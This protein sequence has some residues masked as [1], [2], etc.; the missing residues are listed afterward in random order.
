[1]NGLNGV[2]NGH[3]TISSDDATL[4]EKSKNSSSSH[5]HKSSSKDKHRD[6]DRD[7]HRDHKS[8]KSSHSHSSSTKYVFN[9]FL[10]L[11]KIQSIFAF[12]LK[13]TIFVFFLSLKGIS[14]IAAA[15]VAKTNIVIKID[16]A[17]LISRLAKTSIVTKKNRAAVAVKIRTR[18]KIVKK[19]HRRIKSIKVHDMTKINTNR[20]T[21]IRIGTRIVIV[22]RAHHRSI[23]HPTVAP[24]IVTRTSIVHPNPVTETKNVPKKPLIIPIKMVMEKWQLYKLKRNQLMSRLVNILKFI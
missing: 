14:I 2:S 15:A 3:S 8:S 13:L 18:T 9:D 22:I 4:K 5:H 1:M 7:R 19:L 20:V 16:T 10:S 24:N 11:V 12:L 23:I 6:K 21:E 17:V